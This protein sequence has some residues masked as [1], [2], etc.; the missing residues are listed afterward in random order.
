MENISEIITLYSHAYDALSN[1]FGDEWNN[2]DH[3]RNVII[4][5]FIAADMTASEYL[6]CIWAGNLQ[7]YADT[8]LSQRSI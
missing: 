7:S 2:L 4:A 3:G 6:A 8:L 5:D 1:A